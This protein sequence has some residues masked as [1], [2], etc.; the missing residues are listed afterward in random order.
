MGE[1]S[2]TTEHVSALS[3]PDGP[4]E[5]LERSH[6]LSALGDALTAVQRGGRGRLVFIGG[7]AGVGKTTLVRRFCSEYSESTRVL[8]GACDALF[9]P[10]PLGPL[11]D[12]VGTTPSG[13][14]ELVT[15]GARPHEVVGALVRE[16]Q[17]E[18]PTILVLEDVHWADEATLDVLRLLYRRLDTV[19]ALVLASYRDDELDRGHPLRIVLGELATE[20]T[21]GRLKIEPLSWA[22]VAMLA[23][24][25]GV[26][27]TELHRKTAGN[28]FFVTEVL[29]AGKEEISLTVRDAVFA[30]AARLTPAG[31]TL[32]EAVAVVP[33][34]VELWLLEK[35]AGEAIDCLEECLTSGM[36]IHVP[37]GVAFRHEL[38]RLAVEG[39][40]S[41]IRTHL[42]H[43]MTVD[44]LEAASTAD[45]PDLARLAH[46]AEAAGD[47][48][49]V[50]RF[51][52][53]AAALA[54]SA[55]AHRE[56]AA[57]YAR[58][59]RFSDGLSYEERAELLDRRFHECF[60]TDQYDEAIEAL[61]LALEYHRKLGDRRKEGDSLRSLSQ[62]LWCPGRTAEAE[63]AGRG[64]VAVL[65]RIPPGRE[66]AMAFNNLAE[67]SMA[68]EK[69]EEALAWGTRAL[70]LAQGLD[71]D[72]IS[73]RAHKIIATAE[74]LAGRPGAREKLEEIL[75]R[76]GKM[77]LE[78]EAADAFVCLTW[79]AVRQRS[80]HLSDGYLEAGLRYCG[81][82]GLEVYRLYLLGFGARS[83]LDQGRWSEAVDSAELVLRIPRTSTVPRI[84][85]L[86]T[87]GLVRAR[88]GDPG[89]WAPLDEALE[90]AAPTREL[91]RIAPVAAARAEAAWLEGNEAAIAEA[92]EEAFDLAQDR[93]ASWV[94]GELAY[95]R[96]KAGILHEI[97]PGAAQP[98]AL[99][100]AGEWARA[101]ELWTQIGSP[102]E[103]ALSLADADEDE[104]LRRALDELHR[105]GAQPAAA[106]V[107]RRLR[108][109][110]VRGLPR[111]P[112][113]ATRQNPAN[114]TVREVEVLALVTQ[115]FRNAEIGKRL[116]LS[117][118]TVDHHVSAI[119]R[120]LAVRTRG[121]AAS[122]AARIGLIPQGQ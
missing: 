29:A 95:W 25:H 91:Q 65:E 101:A 47:G 100:I 118:K 20:Q 120:K 59:L 40:I 9:S 111:G 1:V 13:L 35:L 90:L 56:A 89:P 75:D 117:E 33:P 17:A 14:M 30:R 79:G 66:L 84:Q 98:Y 22:A 112:R 103:A 37:E 106:S 109:R 102:Y 61:E 55:G 46:H 18:A 76:A 57:Q 2:S 105:L 99:Q 88:R 114:L 15:N 43:R 85:A 60:L 78:D 8:W 107:A 53:K 50:L 83:E 121:Q 45:R 108:H 52:P 64:A 62:T 38:A 31:R 41:P 82:R 122:E 93:R 97:P 115:G 36:L 87:L 26:D 68:A 80:H 67:L 16:L 4:S 86:V 28:P 11:V 113:A 39:S 23:E 48:E 74:F 7:E 44:A 70:E 10:R 6:E 5:L 69:T 110:G 71:D 72:E 12:I 63:R 42:L 73:L 58:A 34:Q 3:R 24:P 119:L 32:L 51:A 94:I 104:P 92:T 116:F 27:A 81:E 19:P 21:V 49:A 54:A 96:W 77:G